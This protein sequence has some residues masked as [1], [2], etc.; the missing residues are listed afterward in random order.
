M[1]DDASLHD[2]VFSIND[3]PSTTASDEASPSECVGLS[4]P[5]GEAGAPVDRLPTTKR[6]AIYSI[7]NVMNNPAIAMAAVVASYLTRPRHS[8]LKSICACV[9]S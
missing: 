1:E 9:K 3:R 7:A 2:S 6:C 4:L 8:L 5:I